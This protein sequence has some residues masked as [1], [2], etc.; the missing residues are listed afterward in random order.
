MHSDVS[1]IREQEGGGCVVFPP[2]GATRTHSQTINQTDTLSYR[3]TKRQFIVHAICYRDGAPALMLHGSLARAQKC[4]NS[5]R[6]PPRGI[7][8]QKLNYELSLM[9]RR[10]GQ[11]V[12]LVVA[13][14][15][16]EL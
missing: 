6:T 12:F 13:Q 14:H 2:N 1:S 9:F 15:V 8:T 7:E 16:C 11:S 4:K 5:A 10:S 3:D